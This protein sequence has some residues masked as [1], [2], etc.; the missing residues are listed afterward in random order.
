MSLSDVAWF[1][2][3]SERSGYVVVV[4]GGKSATVPRPSRQSSAPKPGPTLTIRAR[5]DDR[6]TATDRAGRD[7]GGGPDVADQLIG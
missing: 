7:A 1:H 3:E 6:S 4:D 2:I 5:G